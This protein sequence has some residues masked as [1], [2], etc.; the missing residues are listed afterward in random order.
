MNVIEK[1]T[2]EVFKVGVSAGA[3][4]RQLCRS[5]GAHGEA[6]TLKSMLETMLAEANKE[7]MIYAANP[8]HV[9]ADGRGWYGFDLD[10]TLAK[11]DGWR[12]PAHIGEPI[13]P[14]MQLVR[15][16][17]NAG[18]EVRIFT[19]RVTIREDGQH[20]IARKAIEEWTETH[21]GIRLKVTNVKDYGLIKLYDDRAVGVQENTGRFIINH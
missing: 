16:F 3:A 21:F 13:E 20:E 17:L 14:M 1:W 15:S 7:S 2:Q 12:G 5:L 9:F 4:A 18:H 11:Y 10:H 6:P 8:H 19:A